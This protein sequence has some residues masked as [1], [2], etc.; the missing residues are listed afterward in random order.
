MQ[1]GYTDLT[2][3]KEILRW[4]FSQYPKIVIKNIDKRYPQVMELLLSLG[5]QEVTE[6]FEMVKVL[7]N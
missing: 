6:Q 2:Q 3:L 7:N 5:A 4:L 1:L